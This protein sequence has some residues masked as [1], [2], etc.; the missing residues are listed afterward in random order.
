M[1]IEKIP[2]ATLW[3]LLHHLLPRTRRRLRARLRGTKLEWLLQKLLAMRK[4]DPAILRRAYKRAF[5]QAD[6]A[7]LRVYK[8]QLWAVLQSTL[9]EADSPT[10]GR[11]VQI[12][13]HFW[14]SMTLWH[15]GLDEAAMAFWQ[16][17]MQAAVETG[18][19]ELAL[20]GFSLLDVY[21]QSSRFWI[22]P[23]VISSWSERLLELITKRYRSI[24][25]KLSATRER[26]SAA[27]VHSLTLPVMPETDAWALGMQAYARLI[28]ASHRMDVEA[29][30]HAA[31]EMIEIL[32]FRVSFSDIY[33]QTHLAS[34]LASLGSC[35]VHLRQVDVYFRWRAVWDMLW[36]AK[37][38]LPLTRYEKLHKYVQSLAFSLHVVLGE[39]DEAYR[40][41]RRNRNLLCELIFHGSQDLQVGF[42]LICQIYW[43]LILQEDKEMS[44]WEKE[45]TL[46]LKG[47][48]WRESGLLWWYWLRW[49]EGYRRGDTRLMRRR[50]G[51]M[52]RLWERCFKA[53]ARWEV[54]LRWMRAV[55]YGGLPHTQRKRLYALYQARE[56]WAEHEGILPISA[57]L[58]A[59]YQRRSLEHTKPPPLGTF[60]PDLEQRLERIFHFFQSVYGS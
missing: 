10:I 41:W 20:W 16:R 34:A 28:Q 1:D 26:P 52:Y 17:A 11:E 53:E 6:P 19:Y 32:L 31:V 13:Q 47:V 39:W 18:W 12:W 2:E 33:V 7:L 3:Q 36:R 49:Y 46:W 29:G 21:L 60:P 58:E 15:A 23:E 5:P 25:E 50:Y 30:L 35:L 51:Q 45:S 42:R 48:S 24:A 55:A 54:L 14:M 56:A 4:Y 27:E 8:H 44:S 38:W 43:V 9:P 59:F 22:A 40:F 57:L 37:A